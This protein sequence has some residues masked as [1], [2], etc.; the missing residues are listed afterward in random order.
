MVAAIAAV[1]ISAAATIG[2]SVASSSAASSAAKSAANTQANS[3][4]AA[5][6]QQNAQFEQTQGNLQPFINAGTSAIGSLQSLTGTNAG[7]N[8][9]TAPL[10]ATSLNGQFAPTQAQ[11]ASTPGYQFQLQQGELAIGNQNASL[12]LAGSGAEGKGLVNYAEGLAG[13]TLATQQAI[14]QQNFQNSL[15]Q[16]QATLGELT[17][18]TGSGQNAAAGLGA[19]G[20]QTQNSVS[21]LTT[22]AGAAQAAGTIGAA[23]ALTGGINSA[24]NAATSGLTQAALIN[25][26]NGNGMFGAATNTPGTGNNLFS[27]ATTDPSNL[28]VDS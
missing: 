11:L 15:T 14:F 6:A 4:A 9:L 20:L 21:A 7:G 24:T 16:Q 23:N 26:L 25:S 19:L 13:T 18:Q 1:G 28:S 27:P 10:S 12:G 5:E 17:Q 22:G 3:A 8:P 2:S